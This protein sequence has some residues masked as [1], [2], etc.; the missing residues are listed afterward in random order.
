MS[1]IISLSLLCSSCRGDVV[2]KASSAPRSGAVSS[3]SK[4][5]S[6]IGIGL[7]KKGVSYLALPYC[8]S[9]QAANHLT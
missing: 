3:E 8:L 6:E 1:L 7:L 9:F 5:C 4:V 2:L